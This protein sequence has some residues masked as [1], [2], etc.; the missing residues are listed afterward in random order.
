MDPVGCRNARHRLGGLSH[1]VRGRARL[2]EPAGSRDVH[3]LSV[4][5]CGRPRDS[6]WAQIAR[7]VRSPSLSDQLKGLK[8][9]GPLPF[10]KVGGGWFQN[11]SKA[12]KT[13]PAT[14]GPRP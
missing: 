4:V 14:I 7:A 2:L 8:R 9:L 3:E 13:T 11:A 10:V 5:G 6:A 12:D 1:D